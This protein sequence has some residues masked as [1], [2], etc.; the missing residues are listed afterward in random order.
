MPTGFL[1][2]RPRYSRPDRIGNSVPHI[3]QREDG[4]LRYLTS[5]EA[6]PL[7]ETAKEADQMTAIE[8]GDRIAR[9]GG[10]ASVYRSGGAYRLLIVDDAEIGYTDRD[11]AIRACLASDA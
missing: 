10:D 9:L 1:L 7:L 5:D 11:A 8:V 3:L 2:Q 4:S 6:R